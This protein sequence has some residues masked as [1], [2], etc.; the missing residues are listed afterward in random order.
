MQLQLFVDVSEVAQG[1]GKNRA[2]SGEV[3]ESLG[4]TGVSESISG[5]EVVA[6][7]VSS[8]TARTRSVAK[9]T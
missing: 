5:S 4:G 6:M 1:F 3:A 2:T 8:R 7:F 9:A